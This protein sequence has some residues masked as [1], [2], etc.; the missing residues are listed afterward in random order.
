MSSSYRFWNFAFGCLIALILGMAAIAVW[1]SNYASGYQSSKYY[2]K[3]SLQLER[4]LQLEQFANGRQLTNVDEDR[5]ES[6]IDW[7]D[8]ATQQSMAEST[9]VAA[10]SAVFTAILTVIG[11]ILLGYTLYFTRET[12]VASQAVAEETRKA[13]RAAQE[14]VIVTREIGQ[15]QARAYL[16]VNS[17]AISITQDVFDPDGDE[18]S[19]KTPVAKVIVWMNNSGQ[20]PARNVRF[21]ISVETARIHPLPDNYTVNGIYY[22]IPDM[23][24]HGE[25]GALEHSEHEIFLHSR[26][27]RDVLGRVWYVLG[28]IAYQDVFGRWY[29]LHFRYNGSLLMP[30][31]RN[32]GPL[33]NFGPV[34]LAREGVG[35]SEEE[36]NDAYYE[37]TF[38]KIEGLPEHA[39]KPEGWQARM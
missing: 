7:C 1:H 21:K 6:G 19:V 14:A 17:V 18:P 39:W 23:P 15:A 5:Q 29:R 32:P 8:L 25:S 33:L 16:S 37:K 20:S 30:M 28:T 24:V 9:S 31:M 2:E 27:A 22:P 36:L 26:D 11:V 34:Q 38:A 4:Q 3:C 13:T 35:N 10:W 12:L